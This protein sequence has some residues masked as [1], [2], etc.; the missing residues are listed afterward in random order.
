MKKRRIRNKRRQI[1]YK[2]KYELG[3]LILFILLI[4][5]LITTIVVLRDKPTSSSEAIVVSEMNV[6]VVS[7]MDL[8][9]YAER[10]SSVLM[11]TP[12]AILGGFL[13]IT[14]EMDSR[15]KEDLYVTTSIENS[16]KFID[17]KSCKINPRTNNVKLQFSMETI[18]ESDDDKLYLF[19]MKTYE[20]SHNSN[21]IATS[22]KWLEG[23][24]IFDFTL[25]R[26]YN[27]YVVAVK[28]NDTFVDL[29]TEHYITN[30]EAVAQYQYSY[31]EAA[32]KKGLIVD[33]AKIKGNE[34]SNLGIKQ[35]AYNIPLGYILGQTSNSHWPTIY[36]DY[37]GN[38]Y[39]FNGQRIAEFDIVFKALT[40]KGIVTTAV[41]LNDY[42]GRYP[43][44][45][46]PNAKNGHAPYYMFNASN[47]EG[48]DYLSAAASFLAKR[49]SGTK[50]GQVVNWVVGNEINARSA[51]NYMDYCSV[52]EY[53]ESYVQ[54]YRVFY[55]AIKSVNANARVYMCLDQ[56]WDRN[57]KSTDSYDAKD[58]LDTFNSMI[59]EKGNIDY[60]IAHH[61]YPV[62]LTWPK[63]WDMPSNYKRMNLV[64]DSVQTPY[65]TVQNLHVLTDYIQQDHYLNEAGE[66]RSVLLNEV[67]FGSDHGETLQ[68]AAYAYAYY[69][70]DANQYVD[71]FILNKQSDMGVEMSQGLS[72]GL[73][74]I[75]GS[76]KYIYN[77]FKNIDTGS[78][79]EATS[80]AKDVIGISDWSQV[81][82]SH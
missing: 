29:S 14:S 63:F 12:E 30:P 3:V 34:L 72:L 2:R 51:W 58:V 55:S 81:I 19:E 69:I 13:P 71:G 42:N 16:S 4:L 59:V 26:L 73:D 50:H 15:R 17:V 39:A 56:M 62:P 6:P 9:D 21:Y 24:F 22:N 52:N 57:L 23:C 18:P 54:A 31:P 8:I 70:I 20:N 5:G 40:Q 38:T 77:V 44:M 68:A 80:F 25:P 10:K 49:Y 74:R 41:L 7:T 37:N 64:R 61:P 75:D 27:K 48:V 43:Q 82:T 78:S 45:I 35:A 60:G 11:T 47:E 53:S 28:Q 79:Y 36:Y 65:I 76:H 33:P 1:R 32:S 67:G 66:V 46:H